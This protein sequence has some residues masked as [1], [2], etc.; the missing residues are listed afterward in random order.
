MWGAE[1]PVVVRRVVVGLERTDL[2]NGS[3][4]LSQALPEAVEVSVGRGP[5]R[6]EL[7]LR[8]RM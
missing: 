4:R 7:V 5:Q 1:E 3:R 2:R 8:K 6:P